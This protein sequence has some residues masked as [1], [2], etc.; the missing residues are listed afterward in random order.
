[1]N[2]RG[3]ISYF[4]FENMWSKTNGFIE[5]VRHRWNSYCFQGCHSFVLAQKLKALKVVYYS[6]GGGVLEAKVEG[7]MVEKGG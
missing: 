5:N 6:F 2:F 4:K 1:V 7:V 3:G